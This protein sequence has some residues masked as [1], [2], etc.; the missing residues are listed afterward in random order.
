ML[1]K[2]NLER[3]IK[4]ILDQLLEKYHPEKVILFGSAADSNSTEINDLDFLVI[5]SNVPHF[6]I[7]RLYEVNSVID[8]GSGAD[9][10]V[11]KPEE[12]AELLEMGDPFIKKIINEGRL[13]YG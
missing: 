4:Y 12:V 7:D 2:E 5:K 11:Y 3:E 1:T 8:R 10:L 9:I 6:G 13:L